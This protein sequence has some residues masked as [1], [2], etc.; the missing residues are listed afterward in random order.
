VRLAHALLPAV[1]LIALLHAAQEKENDEWKDLQELMETPGK[2][3][4]S[5]KL[6]NVRDFD[7]QMYDD[8]HNRPSKVIPAYEKAMNEL[9]RAWTHSLF[10]R[11]T[12]TH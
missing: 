4:L 9:V 8:C 6:D 7:A 12:R 10:R 3:R 5:I 11:R 1:L 2:F